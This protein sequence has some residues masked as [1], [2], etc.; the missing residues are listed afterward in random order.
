[1][2]K[3]DEM[4]IVRFAQC[5]NCGKIFTVEATPEAIEKLKRQLVDKDTEIRRL[6][7][8]LDGAFL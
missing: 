1:M 8:M 6:Q 5:P 2:S 7:A 3:E 4:E